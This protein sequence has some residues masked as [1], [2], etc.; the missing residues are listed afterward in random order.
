MYDDFYSILKNKNP[1][2]KEYEEFQTLFS[3]WLT[4]QQ[5]KENFELKTKPPTG[6]GNYKYLKSNWEP[7]KMS[8][9]V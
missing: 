7:E 6:L 1:L 8:L 4:K 9:V 3:S 2:D 5:A